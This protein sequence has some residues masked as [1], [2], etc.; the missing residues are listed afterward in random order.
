MIDLRTDFMYKEHKI[1]VVGIIDTI[2]VLPFRGI[3][4][5]IRKSTCNFPGCIILRNNELTHSIK[6]ADY[7]SDISF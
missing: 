7:I 1:F 4:L 6:I 5:K 2:P 3:T